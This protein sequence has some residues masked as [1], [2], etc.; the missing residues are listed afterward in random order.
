M[1]NGNRPIIYIFILKMLKT[2]T[3]GIVIIAK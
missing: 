1:V 3:I 2:L